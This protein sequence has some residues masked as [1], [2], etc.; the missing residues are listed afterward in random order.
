MAKGVASTREVGSA[1]KQGPPVEASWRFLGAS[2][3]SMG[4]LRRPE[5]PPNSPRDAPEARPR[6]P[7]KPS[8]E[9]LPRPGLR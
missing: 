9:P 2:W 6:C 8:Q 5:D 3:R 7:T 4:A 1:Q